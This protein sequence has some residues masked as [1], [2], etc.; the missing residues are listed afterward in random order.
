MMYWKTTNHRQNLTWILFFD[1]DLYRRRQRQ[2]VAMDAMDFS[3][4][5]EAQYQQKNVLR[6]LT[7]VKQDLMMYRQNKIQFS[8]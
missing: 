2:V 7:K 6:E 5:H 1:R 8:E 4:N 3:N